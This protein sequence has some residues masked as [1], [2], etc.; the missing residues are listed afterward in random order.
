MSGARTGAR[1]HSDPQLIRDLKQQLQA[2][3]RRPTARIGS[4][5]LSERDGEIW[6]TKTGR[7][8][9]IT[10]VLLDVVAQSPALV[11][12]IFTVTGGPG[13]GTFIINY[14]GRPTDP[15]AYNASAATMLAR[16]LALDPTF[17]ALEFAVQGANG[18][19]W[20]VT[21]PPG[22]LS[23]DATGLTGGTLP[24]VTFQAA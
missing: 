3:D 21:L 19:P 2:V 13:G 11:Q 16:F 5:V 18:G 15:I 7:A 17:T 12:R 20:T 22:E 14:R 8:E 24:D 6:A 4:W 10:G 9:Q 1:A 23:V